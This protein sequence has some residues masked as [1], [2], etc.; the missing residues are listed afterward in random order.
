M[1]GHLS[2]KR[3]IL[4]EYRTERKKK[5]IRML[6]DHEKGN[7]WKKRIRTLYEK[8]DQ[9]KERTQVLDM[10][11]ATEKHGYRFKLD[12]KNFVAEILSL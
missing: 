5:Q 6:T 9:T 1:H 11:T 10:G 7:T 12:E 2:G 3:K 4:K 8:R